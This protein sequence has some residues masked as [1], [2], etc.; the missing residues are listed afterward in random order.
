MI[1]FQHILFP[2]DFSPQSRA[3]AP[4]VKAMAERFQSEI[5]LLHVVEVPPS[6]YG[7]PEAGAYDALI[8]VSSMIEDRREALRSYLADELSG[9]PV[10]RCVQSGD[11]ALHIA[12]YARQ[13]RV[14]LIMMPTHG[15]GP[16]RGL[17]LGSVTAKVLHDAECPVWT[18]AH[19][20]EIATSAGKPW[21]Q[22]ICAVDDELRDVPLVRSAAELA[23][24]QGAEL[25]LVHAVTGFEEEPGLVGDP[26]CDFL[27]GVARERMEKLQHEAGTKLELCLAAGA[28]GKVVRDFA[29]KHSAELVLVGRGKIQKHFGRLRSNAYAIVR[30]APCPVLSQFPPSLC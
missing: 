7:T 1:S 9:I 2:V 29:T 16:F 24:G 15:Y 11:P 8:D 5:M 23:A 19:A 21:R 30:D 20:T 18:T 13:K 14:D 17:L 28:P 22:L 3:A 10:H 4:F 25:R 12:Q 6:W 26:L 27:F